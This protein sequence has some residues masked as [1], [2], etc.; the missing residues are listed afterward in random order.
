MKAWQVNLDDCDTV[1][2]LAPTRSTAITTALR[3]DE[4]GEAEYIHCR[5]RRYAELDGDG[6]R[7]RVLVERGDMWTECNGCY[8]RI[9]GEVSYPAKS[10]GMRKDEETGEWID[11][12]PRYPEESAPIWI[13]DF[14]VFC[15]QG[16][17][18]DHSEIMP[19]PECKGRQGIL[20]STEY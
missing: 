14:H 12:D 15:C 6:I 18:D 9:E 2:V 20:I 3:Y 7:D 13:D 1:Y 5:A 19:N 10:Q 16:C 4:F 8:G 17:R 11:I